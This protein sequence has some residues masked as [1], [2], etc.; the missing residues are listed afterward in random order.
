VNRVLAQLRLDAEASLRAEDWPSLLGYAARLRSEDAEWWPH[1]WAPCVALAE[2]ATGG[3]PVPTLREAVEG[4]FRQPELLPLEPLAALPEWPELLRAMSVPALPPEVEIVRWPAV[5]YG[6]ALVLDRLPGAREA[7]LATR[8]PAREPSAWATARTMLE[9]T[10]TRWEHAND[11]VDSKDALEVL[12][13]AAAGERF[14]CVEYSVLLSQ[15]LNAVGIPARRVS[16]LMRDQHVGFG[17]GHVVSE[18]WIDDLGRWVLLDGQN[19]SWWGSAGEPCGLRELQELEH[20]GVPRPSMCLTAREVPRSDQDEWW[21]YFHAASTS[22]LGWGDS[23]V[24]TFQGE[25]MSLRLVVPTGTPTHPDLSAMETGLTDS[26]DGPAMTFI[27][28]HPFAT[29]VKVGDLGLA[30]GEP[31]ALTSLPV[32]G[33]ELAVHTVTSYGELAAQPLHVVRR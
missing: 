6:P 2:H 4:G 17:R 32:G 16:L 25:P 27:P 19:G 13:R 30:A 5:D 31:F 28:I 18:A 11:H 14:A 9:W 7:E 20:A 3:D 12:D 22:G 1:L 29:G 15:A 23:V 21:R 26:L 10:T 33:N 8:L 24:P